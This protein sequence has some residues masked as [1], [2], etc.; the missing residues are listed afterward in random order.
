MYDFISYLSKR[1]SDLWLSHYETISEMS[2]TEVEAR[3]PKDGEWL[4]QNHYGFN[5]EGDD[6]ESS[7]D[8]YCYIVSIFSGDIS[9]KRNNSYNDVRGGF[10]DKVFD[11]VRYAILEYIKKNNPEKLSWIPIPNTTPN[12][13]TGII[14]FE[15]RK[16]AYEIFAIKS[17]FPDFYVSTK[18]NNWMRRDLYDK[19]VAEK[20][21]PAIPTTL[22]NQSKSIQKKKMLQEIRE[23]NSKNFSISGISSQNNDSNYRNPLHP[24]DPLQSIIDNN[25]LTPATYSDTFN[26]LHVNDFVTIKVHSHRPDASLISNRMI[27]RD[28]N[29]LQNLENLIHNSWTDK[30]IIKKFYIDDS[31]QI[32]VRVQLVTPALHY[33]SNS[34]QFILN[35]N[36]I[37]PYT[38]EHENR[39]NPDNQLNIIFQSELYNPHHYKVG[40]YVLHKEGAIG[41]I[42]SIGLSDENNLHGGVVAD[43]AWDV[44]KSLRK[45]YSMQYVSNENSFN[46]KNRDFEPATQEN[47]SYMMQRFNTTSQPQQMGRRI[48]STNPNIPNTIDYSDE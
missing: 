34:N 45:Y 26:G 2:A 21:Y 10:G 27:Y 4:D 46:L 14:D 42:T 37:E 40:D 6:C 31:G 39:Y 30:M 47:I 18:V 44:N 7:S 16:S 32:F 9:F 13:V 35:I 25:Y 23:F 24:P 43:V 8:K 36:H 11:G 48:T 1:D 29:S 20:G 12:P 19:L 17:L 41:K 33:T 15:A 28:N 5:V 3:K 38:E 22:T